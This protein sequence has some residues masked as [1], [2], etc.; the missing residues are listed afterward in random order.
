M[1]NSIDLRQR[2]DA[3]RR[4]VIV[5]GIADLR[6]QGER[7]LAARNASLNNWERRFHIARGTLQA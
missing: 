2:A 7:R 1:H 6:K 3:D 5:A 4:A